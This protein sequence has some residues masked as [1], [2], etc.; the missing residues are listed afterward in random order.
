M[1]CNGCGNA[2]AHIISG[3]HEPGR[4]GRYIECCDQCGA[5]KAPTVPDV[6]FRE[7]YVDP[8]LIRNCMEEKD[9][10]LITSAKMKA[11]RM[12]ELG[13]REAG[14]RKHGARI[15]DKASMRKNS[16]GFRY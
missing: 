13:V 9:G 5:V 15:E 4:D 8:H 2:N 1:T 3:R 6:Y 12:R 14:D 7:P 10:V 11:E 16:P